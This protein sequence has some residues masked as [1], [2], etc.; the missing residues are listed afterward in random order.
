[1]MLQEIRSIR[2]HRGGAVSVSVG[3]DPATQPDQGKIQDREAR[4]QLT[5]KPIGVEVPLQLVFAKSDTPFLF[6]PIGMVPTSVHV[7]AELNLTGFN[8]ELVNM[9]VTALELKK[10]Y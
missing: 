7:F 1:M 9:S 6:L 4:V 5:R 2:E 3:T 8:V 10:A